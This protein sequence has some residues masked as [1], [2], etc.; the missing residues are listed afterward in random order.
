MKI[1]SLLAK[2]LLFLNLLKI[3]QNNLI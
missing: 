1:I 3:L 2:I